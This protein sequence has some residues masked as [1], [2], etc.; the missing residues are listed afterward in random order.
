M[1][2]I[3][4]FPRELPGGLIAFEPLAERAAHGWHVL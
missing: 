2:V 4:I 1:P 3:G